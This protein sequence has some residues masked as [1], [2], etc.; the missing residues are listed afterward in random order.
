MR[1]K[2]ELGNI[3]NNKIVIDEVVE[4]FEA[5]ANN[6]TLTKAYRHSLIIDVLSPVIMKQYKKTI[7]FFIICY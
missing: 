7:K 5:I 3:M 4:M 2:D 6:N 1:F